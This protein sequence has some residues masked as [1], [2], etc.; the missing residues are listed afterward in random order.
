[1][2]TQL[3]E[4]PPEQNLPAVQGETSSSAVA[5][6]EK[7]AV[8]ARFLVALHRPR[9]FDRFRL[10]LLEACKRPRFA[11][12]ARYAKPVGGGKKAEG[13]SIRFVEEALRHFN[14]VDIQSPAVFDDEERRIVR[15]T[16]TD[17]ESNTS[18]SKDVTLMKT[19]ER[20]QPKPG[21]EVVK[22]RQNS[23]NQ[24]VYII[25]ADEDAFLNK[26]N[27]NVSKEIRNCGLRVL[28]SDIV[29]EAMEQVLK[30]LHDEDA[31]DPTAARKRLVDAFYTLGVMPKAITDLLAHE[32][33]AVTPA[34]LTMLRSIYTAMKDEGT[35]WPEVIEAFGAKKG[36]GVAEDSHAKG[37]EA[38]RQKI[39]QKK[40]EVKGDKKGKSE[41]SDLALDQQLAD[42]E[43]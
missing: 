8:E 6:R 32:L 21:D 20:R 40:A 4:V 2:G 16:V 38:L 22:S 3:T 39:E 41:P 25:K 14:N 34:E 23:Q 15:V 17:L 1:M 10:R 37:T 12:A 30:T 7:A 5:A 26:Q 28:P 19:V 11:E 29:D 27:A 31:K 43:H 33:E 24:T 36:N 9:D 13:P 35:T 42:Q 18:Y